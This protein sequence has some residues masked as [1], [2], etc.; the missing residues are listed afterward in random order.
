M[1]KIEKT[2]KIDQLL[3]EA[4]KPVP[5]APAEPAETEAAAQGGE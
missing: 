4:G 5:A 2:S 3:A 1:P